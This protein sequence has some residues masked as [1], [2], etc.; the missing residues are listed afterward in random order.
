MPSARVPWVAIV[1]EVEIDRRSGKVWARKFT[2]AHDCGLIVNPDGLRRCIEG[3]VVQG[4][5]RA[6]SEEVAFDRAICDP[7]TGLDRICDLAVNGDRIA[8][9]GAGLAPHARQV[10]ELSGKLVTPGWV[11]LHVHVFDGLFSP[12]QPGLTARL[13]WSSASRA[14]GSRV[15]SAVVNALLPED[16]SD[17]HCGNYFSSNDQ[18]PF[19]LVHGE[20]ARN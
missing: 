20:V 14:F 1:A 7:A 3:N 13:P 15:R 9:I 10:I 16:A 2:V 17:D 18:T 19:Q 8:A 4:T 5:S 11:D 6:L 12:R